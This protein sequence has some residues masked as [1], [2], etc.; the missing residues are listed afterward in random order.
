MTLIYRL[1]PDLRPCMILKIGPQ[2]SVLQVFDAGMFVLAVSEILEWIL[3]L[4]PQLHQRPN[5]YGSATEL[6]ICENLIV[7]CKLF[8]LMRM[9][10]SPIRVFSSAFCDILYLQ[11]SPLKTHFNVYYNKMPS[12]YNL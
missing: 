9:E 7:F 4:S 12:R 10:A 11:R 5:N 1:P 6:H 2:A 3:S 8:Y